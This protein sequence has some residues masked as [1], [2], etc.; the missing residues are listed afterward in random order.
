MQSVK[1]FL[2]MLYTCY[3]ELDKQF[4][5]IGDQKITKKARIEAAVLNS[6]IP[7]SKAEICRILPGLSPTTVE[8]VLGELVRKSQIKRIGA[9]RATR[10][11]RS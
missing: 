1:F 4:A 6:L 3:K 9:S 10:Y 5:V 2:S 7:V 11:I 8:A